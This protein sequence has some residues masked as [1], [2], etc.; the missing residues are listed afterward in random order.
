MN[1]KKSTDKDKEEEEETALFGGQFKGHCHGCGKIGHRKSNC[2]ESNKNGKSKRTGDFKNRSNYKCAHCGKRG[3]ASEKCWAKFGKPNSDKVNFSM[4]GVSDILL[5]AFDEIA[6][7]SASINGEFAGS[8]QYQIAAHKEIKN[9]NMKT[10]KSINYFGLGGKEVEFSSNTWIGDSGASCHMTNDDS[11]MFETNEIHE[12]ITIGNG[13]PMIATKVGKIKV[14][15]VQN[16][17]STH[18]FT[19]VNV[20]Y[21]PELFCKLFSVTVALDKGFQLGNKGR[22]IILKKGDFHI[23]FDKVFNTKTGF[24]SGVDLIPQTNELVQAALE[25][26]REVNI[27]DLHQR[28]GHPSEEV[29]RKTAHDLELKVTG[30]FIKCE[31]CAISKARC[32]N[33]SREIAERSSGKGDRLFIDISSI[34]SESLGGRKFWLL[35][36]DDYSDFCFSYFLKTKDELSNTMI[37]LIKELKIKKDIMVK[38]IRCNNTGEKTRFGTQF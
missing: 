34:K 4:E 14:D 1:L 25:A 15:L 30:K 12:E 5:T 2:P 21:V 3:H 27:N 29:V 31:N 36:V 22:V 38:T 18:Q 26:G 13:K 28:L 16:D 7:I 6:G 8:A 19:M 32:K 17:G 23:A 20:K 35:A 11:G 9:E 37:D 24:I 33:I 10:E